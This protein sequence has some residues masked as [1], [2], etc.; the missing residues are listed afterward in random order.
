MTTSAMRGVFFD[1]PEARAELMQ[2]IQQPKLWGDVLNRE[3]CQR[4][5]LEPV[6][7]PEDLATVTTSSNISF[8]SVKV[9]EAGFPMFSFV[10]E[11]AICAANGA[12]PIL[13]FWSP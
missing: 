9:S 8:R 13:M 3:P 2:L 10:L 4:A 1:R 11:P 7:G 6:D 12:T 5:G